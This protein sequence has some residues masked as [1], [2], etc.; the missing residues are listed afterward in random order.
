[1][2]TNPKFVFQK[3]KIQKFKIRFPKIQKYKKLKLV[4]QNSEYNMYK[5]TKIQ[6]CKIHFSDLRIFIFL[7]FEISNLSI[8]D[9]EI[10]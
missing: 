7:D 5:N 8:S 1:M 9:F 3:S 10:F 6:K 2:Y 4:F